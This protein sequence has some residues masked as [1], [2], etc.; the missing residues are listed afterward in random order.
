MRQLL[1]GRHMV[2]SGSIEPR[3]FYFSM[4]QTF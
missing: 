3:S 1:R 4:G 2:E